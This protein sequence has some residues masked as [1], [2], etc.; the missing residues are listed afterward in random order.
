MFQ[1]WMSTESRI[2][3]RI[4]SASAKESYF[5]GEKK[6]NLINWFIHSRLL[7]FSNEYSD[8]HIFHYIQK[9]FFSLSLTH[10]LFHLLWL[11]ISNSQKLLLHKKFI[12]LQPCG[13]INF[14]SVFFFQRK[15]KEKNPYFSIKKK[16]G[17]DKVLFIFAN[18]MLKIFEKA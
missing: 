15:K 12:V 7:Y 8:V 3:C 9:S 11:H 17:E 10:S 5:K 6:F 4:H 2:C 16:F 13:K 1:I 18:W 14:A